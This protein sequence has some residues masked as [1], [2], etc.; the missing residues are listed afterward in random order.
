MPSSWSNNQDD[1]FDVAREDA[2]FAKQSSSAG[3]GATVTHQPLF[4]KTI[5]RLNSDAAEKSTF[6]QNNQVQAVGAGGRYNPAMKS[7]EVR[8]TFLSFFEQRGHT[9]VPSAPL[10]PAGDATLM[11]TNAGMVPFKDV[12]L[13]KEKRSYKRA[14]SCQKCLRVS[15]KHNDLDEVG[16]SSHHHTFFEMLGNFSFGDYF[17]EEA[18]DFWWELLTKNF[19]LPPEKLHPTVFTE[20]DESAEIWS[21]LTGRPSSSVV[22]LGPEDNFWSMGDTG[23]CGP[24][25]EII[26]DRTGKCLRDGSDCPLTCECDRWWEVGNNVFMQ[27]DRSPDGTLT[28]LA[29]VGVDTGMG[30]ERMCAILQGVD[31]SYETDIFAPIFAE[32]TRMTGIEYSNEPSEQRT[33]MRILADHSRAATFLIA[34]GIRPSNEGRGYVLRRILRRASYQ[35]RSIGLDEPFLSTVCRVVIETMADAYP[36]I[37]TNERTILELVSDEEVRFLDTLDAGLHRLHQVVAVQPAVIKITAVT[38]SV[39]QGPPPERPV[40]AGEEAFR[41]YDTYGF[42]IDLTRKVLEGLGWSVDEAGFDKALEE[43]RERG[44]EAHGEG[45]EREN[46]LLS[47]TRDLPATGFVGYDTME[48][49]CCALLVF[50]EGEAIDIVLDMSPFYAEG[51]GQ[52]GDRGKIAGPNGEAQIDS[53]RRLGGVFV[54]SGRITQGRIETDDR[55]RAEVD[56]TARR[57]TMR[58]HTATHLLHKALRVVLGPQAKQAGSLVAPDR[59]RFDFVHGKPLTDDE[60]HEVERLV[61]EQ[62]LLNNGVQTKVMPA[63]EAIASGADA[64][65]DEKYG[66]EARVVSVANGDVFSRELC[67]GTHV[68]ATG[69]IGAFFIV[70]QRSVGAGVRRVEAVTGMGA[71]DYVDTRR[72]IVEQLAREYNVPAT[73]LPERIHALQER[74]KESHREAAATALPDPAEVLSKAEQRNGTAIV[75]DRLESVDANALREFGDVLRQKAK[76][77]AIVLGSV[78]DGQPNIVVMLTADRVEAGLHAG[79]LAQQLGKMMGAGGGGR[80]DVATAGGKDASQLDAALAKARELLRPEEL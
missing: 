64:M 76:S 8:E 56:V 14:T 5:K 2:V 13:G 68:H 24:N 67:G 29:Q 51:G 20:D 47:A 34:D 50:G 46:E 11:F 37:R 75:V 53:V 38:P 71:F 33:A 35:G 7:S 65:F 80:P 6:L 61:R 25:S 3:R 78:V 77:A 70:E 49:E 10:V 66:E 48:T 26:Y 36:E 59:L 18:L 21:K 60:L 23:P 19:A 16:P 9:R 52:A 28:P 30:F 22:R 79:K 57:A 41:L 39:T 27:Y 31:S 62:I 42:P 45:K 54:H 63:Q 1:R 32:I 17:K 40:L 58:N 15:G 43:Q 74:A 12:F 72:R 44:R 4:G 55:V 69:E 73:E